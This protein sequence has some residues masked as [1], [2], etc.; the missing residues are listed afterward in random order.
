V[1]FL[2]LLHDTVLPTVCVGIICFADSCIKAC[3]ERKYISGTDHVAYREIWFQV[4]C[5][6]IL[7]MQKAECDL[8]LLDMT[9]E[10]VTGVIETK[11]EPDQMI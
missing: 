11:D 1:T 5:D 3:K 4:N 6:I 2:T 8:L 9:G 7:D 10:H